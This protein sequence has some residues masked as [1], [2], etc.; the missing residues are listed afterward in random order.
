ME[1]GKVI[2]EYAS[3]DVIAGLTPMQIASGQPLTVEIANAKK[4]L[5]NKVEAL[6][7]LV[8]EKKETGGETASA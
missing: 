1:F 8:T 2:G 5:E 4:E 6:A 3:P 7:R